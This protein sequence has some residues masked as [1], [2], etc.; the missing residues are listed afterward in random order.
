MSS[1]GKAA[2]QTGKSI[3]EGIGQSSQSYVMPKTQMS[4][5]SRGI[6][7]I[8][9]V[10]GG[11]WLLKKIL[12]EI[13]DVGQNKSSREQV[14][15]EAKELEQEKKKKAPTLSPSQAA[16]I[17]NV[18]HAAMDGYGT[19]ESAI[20]TQFRKIKT[21]ADYLMVSQAYGVKKVSSGRFN[22]EP[23]YEGTMAGALASEL[24]NTY[25]VKLNTILKNNGVTAYSI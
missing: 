1:T 17:A 10:I 22:P 19:D 5:M 25:R 23:D 16:S 11:L 7:T 8:G 24:D 14:N 13:E 6:L 15:Q 3:T 18:I 2:A 9:A 21:N 4:A 20:V 12:G